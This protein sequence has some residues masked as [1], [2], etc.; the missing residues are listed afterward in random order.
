MFMVCFTIFILVVIESVLWTFENMTVMGFFGGNVYLISLLSLLFKCA[1]L[2]IDEIKDIINMLD[3]ELFL[4]Y[5]KNKSH[6]DARRMFLRVTWALILSCVLLSCWCVFL[7]KNAFTPAIFIFGHFNL[8]N[9]STFLY[10][11]IIIIER[12]GKSHI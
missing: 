3:N 5:E 12:I 4:E 6:Y 10:Q 7:G 2:N 11:F 1:F 8:L 9:S